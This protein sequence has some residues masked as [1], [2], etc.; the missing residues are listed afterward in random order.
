M[1][2]RNHLGFLFLSLSLVACASKSSRSPSSDDHE[3]LSNIIEEIHDVSKL[4]QM[5]SVVCK[6]KYEVLY[7]KLF[8]LA[9]DAAYLEFM[10][11][12]TMDEE[13][14]SSFLA[15][16]DLKESLKSFGNDPECL[17][18]ATDV[19]RGLRYVEDYLIELRME[20]AASGP[21]EYVD[22]KGDFPYLLINP[23]YAS[24]FKS[25]ED[26]KSGDV[27]L[28]R[29]NAFSSAAIARIGV[30][31]YQFSHLAFVY[32][33]AP[34]SELMTTEAF[35][36]IGSVAAP[37]V[38][39]IN[40][41]NSRT[42]VYRYQDPQIAHLA[43]KIMFDRVLASMETKKGIEYDFVMDFKEDSRLYC[44]E[45]ISSG[46]KKML[47]EE[48]FFPMYKSK[49]SPGIIP[50]LNTMG[51]SVTKENIK[52]L[53]IFAPGDVQFDPRFEMVAEWRNPRKMEESRLKDFILTALFQRMDKEK[54]NF[55][56]T[57]KMDAEARTLW[58][59]RRTPVVRKFI[60][61]KFPLNMTTA[62]LEL[63]M[64]MDK[65][66][67]EIYREVEKASLEF[68]RPMTPKEIYA[69]LDEFF[70]QDFELYKRYKKGQDVMKPAFHLLFHP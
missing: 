28:S 69:V 6:D 56:S 52:D 9:G 43:S 40:S 58:L 48:D 7:K 51:I 59:L 45:I 22:L 46:F 23:K 31:D 57:I 39:H 67:E 1:I 70:K 18:S 5:S 30:N 60:Q 16:I 26:L 29:G 8:N 44:A 33:E 47:P 25:Y 3:T 10:D 15:R 62:Q 19:F 35:I 12:K 53:E 38:D 41:K 27:I 11:I 21:S 36:E 24:E 34:G 14:K 66:G 64:A 55:D 49:F 13:I 4:Q 63:F 17:K 68:D 50:F 61:N 42:V 20:K 32:Q 65:V 2:T 54:Y 37:L